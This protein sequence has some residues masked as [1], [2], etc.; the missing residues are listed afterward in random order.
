MLELTDQSLFK[1]SLAAA[2]LQRN[3]SQDCGGVSQAGVPRADAP[4]LFCLCRRPA[5]RAAA[6]RA[7]HARNSPRVGVQPPRQ[8]FLELMAHI[9]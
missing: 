4:L 2:A 3:K 1:V 7:V 9:A 8:V 5:A 6:A